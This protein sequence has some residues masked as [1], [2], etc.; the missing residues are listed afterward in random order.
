M[1]FLGLLI[2]GVNRL[3]CVPREKILKALDT[4]DQVLN[5][6]KTTVHQ[7][8]KICGYLNFLGRSI[9]PGRAFTRRLY[10]VGKSKEEKS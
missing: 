4:I 10:S 6:K 1:V 3:V 9:V 5:F 7:M 2:D 8:Q